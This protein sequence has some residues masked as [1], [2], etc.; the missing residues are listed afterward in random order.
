MSPNR[1]QINRRRSRIVLKYFYCVSSCRSH[2]SDTGTF[3]KKLLMR[4]YV[5]VS[6]YK[7]IFVRIW[8]YIEEPESSWGS[9][10]ENPPHSNSPQ[11]DYPEELLRRILQRQI[12]PRSSSRGFSSSAPQ[13]MLPRIISL[14]LWAPTSAKCCQ[15]QSFCPAVSSQNHCHGPL[16]DAGP[17]HTR[18]TRLSGRRDSVGAIWG[19]CVRQ[20]RAAGSWI[21]VAVRW[22]GDLMHTLPWVCCKQKRMDGLDK[23]TNMDTCVC[24]ITSERLCCCAYMQN[25]LHLH[26]CIYQKHW[27]TKMWHTNYACMYWAQNCLTAESA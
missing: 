16:Q 13:G 8:M 15:T 5:Y 24:M 22:R 7:Y 9:P 2:V 1:W 11:E 12:L 17:R 10:E 14:E 21:S 3:D 18:T 6:K 26:T 19:R 4:T 23:Q 20:T 27:V 25:L